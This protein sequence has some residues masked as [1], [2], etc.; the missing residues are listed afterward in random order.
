MGRALNVSVDLKEMQ[1]FIDIA[2]V[3]KKGKTVNETNFPDLQNRIQM[4]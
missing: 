1:S 3:R 2:F 4:K